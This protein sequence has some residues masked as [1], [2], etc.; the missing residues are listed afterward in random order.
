MQEKIRTSKELFEK[1]FLKVIDLRENSLDGAIKELFAVLDEIYLFEGEI[2]FPNDI[3]LNMI[4]SSLRDTLREFE[5]EV[6]MLQGILEN[7]VS[8]LK[9]AKSR[10]MLNQQEKIRK[11]GE[12]LLLDLQ[13]IL[14]AYTKEER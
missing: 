10:G 1:K 7:E 3:E 5:L 6:V 12:K 2:C 9:K 14:A 8:V 11:M 4:A 13:K